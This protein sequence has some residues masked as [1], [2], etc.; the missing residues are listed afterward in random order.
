MIDL[1][2]LADRAVVELDVAPPQIE[3]VRARVHRRRRRRRGLLAGLVALGLCGAAWAML[4]VAPD[5][6]DGIIVSVE[7]EPVVTTT[8]PALPPLVVQHER[9]EVRV[10]GVVGCVEP[11][12]ADGGFDSAVI[13]TWADVPGRRWRTTVTYPDGSS[14]D[15]VVE[16]SA[17]YPATV[18]WRG[19]PGGRLVGCRFPTDDTVLAGGPG[20]P[21]FFSL[22]PLDE[23]TPTE[24]AE[25]T[26]DFRDHATRDAEPG[27]D[28]RGRSAEVWRQVVTGRGS[29]GTREAAIEQI[30]VWYVEA[31]TGRILEHRFTNTWEGIGTAT[32][33]E[34]LVDDGEITVPFDHFA[35]DGFTVEPRPEGTIQGQLFLAGGPPPGMPTPIAGTVTLRPLVGEAT[36][37]AVD[38][39]G[40]YEV[41]LP[42]GTYSVTGSSPRSLDGAPCVVPDA[43]VVR[44]GLGQQVDIACLVP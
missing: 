2:A 27:V 29:A 17:H 32:L 37:V 21:G 8:A 42:A 16:P 25:L 43:V 10:E 7:P 30:D 35:T 15:T 41:A 22:N 31:D 11:L 39:D 28:S 5:G 4:A 6:G 9:I 38:D 19:E 26:S 1:D 23:L 18:A 12:P 34:T 36:T 44:H 3:R 33:T 14:I 13:D 20:Q 40:R 24:R